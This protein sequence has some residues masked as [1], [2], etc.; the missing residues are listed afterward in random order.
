MYS[1]DLKTVRFAFTGVL[2]ALLDKLPTA[3]IEKEVEGGVIVNAEVFGNGI[4]MWL[5]SQGDRVKLLEEES[6]K[7]GKIDNVIQNRKLNV[8]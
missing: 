6:Y 8:K 3:Q 4:D 5:R 1:G 7:Y 2:E